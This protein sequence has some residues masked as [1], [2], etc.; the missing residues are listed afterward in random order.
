MNARNKKKNIY[1]RRVSTLMNREISSLFHACD[2]QISKLRPN[3]FKFEYTVD[4][5]QRNR[6][7]K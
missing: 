1:I 7:K 2:K 6:S 5:I 4:N 3:E